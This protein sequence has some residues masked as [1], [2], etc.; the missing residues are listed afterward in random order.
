MPIEQKKSYD[1]EE[2]QRNKEK[3]MERQRKCRLNPKNRQRY[4]EDAKRRSKEW[5]AK[6]G[7]KERRYM[8]NR[9]SWLRQIEKLEKIAGRKRP[10]ACEICQI[11]GVMMFD[12]D[13]KTGKFR[14]WICMKC[15]TVL[16]KVN[17][18]KKILEALIS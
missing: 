8:Y 18:D 13:H 12:H 2:Y 6:R 17:D 5:Y 14:G 10:E 15:N 7:N 16:G 1:P 3:Y 11:K 9:A 4:L